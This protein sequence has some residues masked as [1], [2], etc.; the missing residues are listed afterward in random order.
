MSDPTLENDQQ[1]LDKMQQPDADALLLQADAL[2]QQ[3]KFEQAKRFY[4]QA[5]ASGNHQA[6]ADYGLGLI[7]AN[8]NNMLNALIHFEAAIKADPK[9][10]QYWVSY[11]DALLL[12]EQVGKVREAIQL[13]VKYGLTSAYAYQLESD[14]DALALKLQNAP[15][16]ISENASAPS[17]LPLYVLIPAYRETYL[18]ELLAG[19]FA[20][21]YKKFKVIISDDSPNKAVTNLLN[22]PG[23]LPIVTVLDIQVVDGPQKGT[24]SNI[25]HLITTC[26]SNAQYVHVLFDDDAIYP[27]FYETHITAHQLDNVGVSVSQRWKTNA[28]GLPIEAHWLPDFMQSADKKI[29]P[30]AQDTLFKSVVPNCNNWLGEFSNSVFTLQTVRYYCRSLLGDIPYYGLGDIGVMLEIGIDHQVVFIKEH[31]SVFRQHG[32]QHTQSQHSHVFKCG[33][34]AWISLAISSY[35]LEKINDSELHRNID[36][37]FNLMNKHYQ[38]D[39][40]IQAFLILEK[41]FRNNW[42][43]FNEGFLRFWRTY[44]NHKDWVSAQALVAV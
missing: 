44:I 2:M 35:Q 21:T 36:Y 42:S 29:I 15:P 16:A 12:S 7:E 40:D 14:A 38:Q 33:L 9:N 10:E 13:G 1:A 20:Q 37:I 8:A 6:E 39:D 5:L 43:K 30:L 23:I 11:I 22:D 27:T 24:M 17:D 4:V 32:S 26:P 18:P 25:V 41:D 31:L 3:N 28:S 34:L 19:L